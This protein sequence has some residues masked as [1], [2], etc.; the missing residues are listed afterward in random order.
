MTAVR[1]AAAVTWIRNRPLGLVYRDQRKSFGGSTLDSPVRG[2]HADLLDA[3]GRVV[4][5]WEKLPPDVADGSGQVLRT[6]RS[7]EHLS[8]DHHVECPLETRRE[9]THN[10]Q[11]FDNGCQQRDAPSFSQVVEVDRQSKKV[12]W[13]YQ[14]TPILASY[15]FMISGAERLPNGNVLITEGATG[16]LFEIT[17][18]GEVVWELVSPWLLPSRFGDT[19]AAFRAYRVAGDDSRLE[20][21]ARSPAPFEK[22]NRRTAE[23]KL[24]HAR[25]EPGRPAA[26]KPKG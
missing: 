5:Q 23:G 20:G 10:I 25:D 2:H 6:W 18:G 7:W 15:S 12:V 11:V 8:T 9:W 3:S 17:P 4:H 1:Q 24:L 26:A 21:L 22:I 14:A 19:T 13:S 16:R